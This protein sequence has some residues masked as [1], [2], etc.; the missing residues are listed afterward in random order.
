MVQVLVGEL[1]SGLGFSWDYMLD[2]MLDWPMGEL[3]AILSDGGLDLYSE[4][5]WDELLAIPSDGE[6]VPEK[7]HMLDV[8]LECW[9]VLVWD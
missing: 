2:H 7:V 8:W 1:V 6:L 4:R 5:M 3:L 9:L